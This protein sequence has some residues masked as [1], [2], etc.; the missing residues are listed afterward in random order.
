[1]KW[2]MQ[3]RQCAGS[4]PAETKKRDA[5]RGRSYTKTTQISGLKT[6]T[7]DNKGAIPVATYCALLQE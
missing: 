5:E 3:S 1:M 2:E 4:V 7:D 6:V